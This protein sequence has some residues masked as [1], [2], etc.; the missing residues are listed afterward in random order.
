MSEEHVAGNEET[1]LDSSFTAEE[2]SLFHKRYEEG[3]NLHDPHYAAWLRHYLG[4]IPTSTDLTSSCA[5]SIPL[6]QTP[7]NAL[8]VSSS[9][10]PSNIPGMSPSLTSSHTLCVSPLLH[11][12]NVS[13]SLT[14]S[15]PSRSSPS[16]ISSHIPCAS[17]SLASFSAPGVSPLLASCRSILARHSQ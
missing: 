16:H 6:P 17:P 10:I 13:M 14:P 3:Y 2:V 15:A 8:D 5:S 7:F 12:P 1:C 11:A 9:L 4:S